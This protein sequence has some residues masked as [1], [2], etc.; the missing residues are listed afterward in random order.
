MWYVDF[1]IPCFSLFYSQGALGVVLVYLVCLSI[2]AIDSEQQLSISPKMTSKVSEVISQQHPGHRIM[3]MS[4]K[5]PLKLTVHT[6][7]SITRRLS[8]TRL[9]LWQPGQQGGSLQPSARE[10]EWVQKPRARTPAFGAEKYDNN[11]N[12]K[13]KSNIC[14]GGI[15]YQYIPGNL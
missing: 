7:F 6:A 13:S 2:E 4:F 10:G 9:C 15:F 14:V 12:N 11:N 3:C 8:W 1:K 5:N